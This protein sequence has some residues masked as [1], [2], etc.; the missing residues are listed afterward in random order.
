[1][2]VLVLESSHVRR[3]YNFVRDEHPSNFFQLYPQ[4][5]CYVYG[6]SGGRIGR[7]ADIQLFESM[8]QTQRPK[9]LIINLLLLWD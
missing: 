7:S 8:I 9:Q 5:H 1:M 6:I 3:L 2:Y 4:N